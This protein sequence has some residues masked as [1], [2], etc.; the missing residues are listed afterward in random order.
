MN[1]KLYHIEFKNMN[2]FKTNLTKAK[3]G[4]W[5]L[6]EGPIWPGPNR[7]IRRLLYLKILVKNAE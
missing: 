7:G 2:I 1:T 3:T 6:F 5:Y 4:I